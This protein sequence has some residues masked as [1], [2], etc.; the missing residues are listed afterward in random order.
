MES[1]PGK[2]A[3][4]VFCRPGL[5]SKA[6]SRWAHA[7]PL[8]LGYLASYV[9]NKGISV[10]IVDAKVEHHVSSDMTA[11]A[12]M[13]R[14]PKYV[15]ISAMTFDFPLAIL[16]A[17]KLKNHLRP[18]VVIFGGP[19]TSA[20]PEKSL[21]ET[22]AIDFI[23]VGQAE[24]SIV[25][26]LQ[27]LENNTGFSGVPGLYW[28]AAN[29]TILHN[30]QAV[31]FADLTSLPFPAWDFWPSQ[32]AYPVM[33]ERGCPF[34]C[35]FCCHNMGRIMR[36]R[37]I[38][39][40]MEEIHWL[41]D[42]FG[43]EVIGFEDE[44]FGL[45][46][47]RTSELL[48]LCSEFNKSKSLTFIAQTRADIVTKE[49][50]TLMKA[51]GFDWISIGIESGDDKILKNTQKDI[52]VRQIEE[53]VRVARSAGLKLWPKFIIGLPGETHESA[54]RT[55]RLAVR[56]NPEKFGVAVI[57]AY[58]GCKIYEWALNKE[59]GYRFL[60]N[61]WKNFDKYLSTSIELETLDIRALKWLQLRL[62]LEVYLRNWRLFE[63]FRLMAN[64]IDVVI[65][66]LKSVLMPYAKIN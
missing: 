23:L 30:T 57:V 37:P 58:P 35:V 9:R 42:K 43:A 63:L 54:L 25:K 12:I 17:E 18:P 59:N 26:L 65:S 64:E 3:T 11:S 51:A 46:K 7:L 45:D 6:E 44:T 60:S 36:S 61:D 16:I 28:R 2:K 38:W 55:I 15:G 29:G 5:T 50:V 52:T 47:N 1:Y 33:T 56:I 66:I 4:I 22:T 24:E 41:K 14:Q 32:K 31:E 48:R 27:C 10:A 53:S 21:L 19:H 40:V 20:L 62:F 13:E 34:R 49:L 8:G 39:H